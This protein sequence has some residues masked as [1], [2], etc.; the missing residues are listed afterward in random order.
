MRVL[1]CCSIAQGHIFHVCSMQKTSRAD[2]ANTTTCIL[3]QISCSLA[4][5]NCEKTVKIREL[6]STL[7]LPYQM[8]KNDSIHRLKTLQHGPTSEAKSTS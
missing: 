5:Q 3:M 7:W 4:Q 8:A 2:R 6:K 1:I